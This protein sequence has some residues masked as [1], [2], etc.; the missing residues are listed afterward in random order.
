MF[1]M[2]LPVAA[3][4][5]KQNTEGVSCMQVAWLEETKTLMNTIKFRAW[6]INSH[7]MQHVSFIEFD[8]AG[9]ICNVAIY[10]G[11]RRT[12]HGSHDRFEQRC[13][14][15]ALVLLQYTGLKDKAGAEICE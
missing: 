1:Q 5:S 9:D 7:S 8:A 3:A 2:Q 12:K 13:N 10:Q 11:H 14:G 6:D 4:Q 15:D